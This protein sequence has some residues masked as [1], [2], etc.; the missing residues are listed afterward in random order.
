MKKRYEWILPVLGALWL[1]VA[2]HAKPE[3]DGAATQ[4]PA[5]TAQKTTPAE[6]PALPD[7]AALD[8][9]PP[10][11]L[12]PVASDVPA[13]PPLPAGEV[14]DPSNPMPAAPVTPIAPTQVPDIKI[15]KGEEATSLPKPKS[16][17][18]F[19][20]F[21]P[22]YQWQDADD[23]KNKNADDDKNKVA[24]APA[25]KVEKKKPTYWVDQ[26][27]YRNQRL[28][29]KIYRKTYDAENSHLPIAQYE[30]D[31]DAY[32]FAAAAR[33][34]LYSLRA[35]IN[36]GR[37]LHMVNASG[38]TLLGVAVRNNAHD[39]VRYL[40]AKGLSP[41]MADSYRADT[42]TSAALRSVR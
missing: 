9:A 12:E 5:A 34:D 1:P 31:Y 28:P 33:N 32:T 24:P 11:P 7:M 36:A 41:A 2:A 20:F 18:E 29:L 40:L 39:T 16:D 3:T 21:Q 38:E 25:P 8:A 27:N 13:M 26:F 23:G 15:K 22:G 17:E 30:S 19:K 14:F 10:A 35:L 37:S 6:L 42:Q 4:P